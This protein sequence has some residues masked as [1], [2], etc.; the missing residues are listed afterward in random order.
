MTPIEHILECMDT[1]IDELLEK[2]QKAK[3]KKKQ[4]KYRDDM[5]AIIDE[6]REWLEPYY[7]NEPYPQIS[8]IRVFQ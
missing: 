5:D 3:S 1:R 7:M 4:E 6:Y 8:G 2:S